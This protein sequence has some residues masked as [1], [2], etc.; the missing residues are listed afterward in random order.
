[1]RDKVGGGQRNI[2]PVDCPVSGFIGVNDYIVGKVI[3]QNTCYQTT[4][5]EFFT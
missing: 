2:H 4:L 1:M 3:S 5:T